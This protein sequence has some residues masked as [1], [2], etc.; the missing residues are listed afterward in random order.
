ML[1]EWRDGEGGEESVEDC[2]L[3]LA[4]QQGA[5][6]VSATR[7]RRVAGPGLPLRQG[8]LCS[9]VAEC[10]SPVDAGGLG[11]PPPFVR[12]LAESTIWGR[13]GRGVVWAPPWGGVCG[14]G[15]IQVP[16]RTLPGLRKW[17]RAEQEAVVGP[18]NH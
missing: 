13:C 6:P 10:T 16:Y 12:G 8:T 9:T 15:I 7:P 2:P 4:V 11:L 1:G 17:L 14:A 18:S 3:E 5:P